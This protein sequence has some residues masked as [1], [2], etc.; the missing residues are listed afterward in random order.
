MNDTNDLWKRC[1][2][3]L[4]EQVSDATWRTWLA[5]LAPQSFDGN[6]LVLAAPSTLVRDRVE[7]R[8]LGML[9]A[10]A[11]EAAGGEVKIRLEV[12]AANP[13]EVADTLFS[14]PL[15]D[16]P[17]ARA[18]PARPTR[19]ARRTAGADEEIGLDPRYTFDA[20]VI[21]PTNRFAHAAALAV[22]EMPA[23]SYNPL[24]IHGEAGLGKT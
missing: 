24:F 4:R 1:G 5:G 13:A 17:E 8:F 10:A 23:L 20:F 11:Q 14:A 6:L 16:E 15:V 19:S 9:V 3:A 7:S 22:A 18:V 12:Q 21:G 2:E